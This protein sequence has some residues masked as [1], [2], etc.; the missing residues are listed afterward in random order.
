L[1]TSPGSL[2]TARTYLGSAGTQTAALAF[3]GETGT[4]YTGATEEYNGTS[5][6]TSNALNT[7]RYRLG[8]AGIQTA[9]LAFGGGD[10]AGTGATEEYDGNSWTTSPGSLNTTRPA[11][12]GAGTQTAGLAF[13]GGIFQLL[14]VQQK[15]ITEHLGQIVIIYEHSKI[16]YLSRCRFTNS[17]FSFW[18]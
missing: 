2:N 14:Q 10:G 7:A 3:G 6:T 5:W 9:A 17:S 18:W 11:L 13:G 1:D 8:D 16:D 15:N 4:A 12:A